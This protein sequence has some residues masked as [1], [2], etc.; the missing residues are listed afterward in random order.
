MKNDI[1][2]A[3]SIS[4]PRKQSFKQWIDCVLDE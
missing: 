3:I 1:N 2:A 4:E